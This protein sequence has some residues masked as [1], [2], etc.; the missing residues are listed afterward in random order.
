[1]CGIVAAVGPDAGRRLGEALGVIRHRGPDSEGIHEGP[2]W[3]MGIRR[4]AIIDVAGGDQ[5]IP[6]EDETIWVVVNGEIY[7][8]DTLRRDL[9]ARGHRFRTGSDAEVVVHLYEE[10]GDRFVEHLQGMFGLFLATPAGCFVARDRLGIKPLYLA[11][12]EGTIYIASEIRSLF[13]LPGVPRPSTDAERLADY[14]LFRYVPEPRTAFIGIERFPA[15]HLLTIDRRGETMRRY[16][17]L[18]PGTPYRGSFEDAVAECESRLD[19][20]VDMHLMSERP[21][22]V[23]LSGGLD[24]SV[25]SAL[26]VRRA[27]HPLVA[28][29]AAFPGSHLDEAGHARLVA[30]HLGIEHHLLDLAATGIQDLR[31]AVHV[32]ED[33]VADPALMPFLKVSH[34]ARENLTVALVGEGSDET[35]VGYKGFLWMQKMLHRRRLTRLIPLLPKTGRLATKLGHPGLDELDFLARYTNVGIPVDD[36]PPFLDGLPPAVDRIRAE[37]ARLT[38][39]VG[40]MSTLGRNRLYRIEGWM[41]DDL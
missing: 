23:F 19:T 24:S 2:G 20:I 8:H 36:Y 38:D 21:V 31:D 3:A 34:R 35:N 12:G 10:H 9:I 40:S 30:Q 11:R 29:T 26:A 18:E 14:F 32:V 37:I 33:L 25:L 13:E 15:G 6:N 4:L 41:K 28:L 17:R 27:K 39:R 7:N 1:M 16:W 5:P 22:G